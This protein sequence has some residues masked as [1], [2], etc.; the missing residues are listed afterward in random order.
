[1]MQTASGKGKTM[2]YTEFR[3]EYKKAI[4]AYPDIT[5]LYR[6]TEDIKEIYLTCK[7]Y[8]KSG[9]KW[10]QT[11]S[12]PEVIDFLHYINIVDPRTI[13]FFRNLGGYER[14]NKSYTKHGLLPV[15][16]VSINPDR[17]IK[18]V[19]RFSFC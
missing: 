17:T 4:K 16:I 11:A 15:E 8:I 14:V 7:H 19:Y 6:D 10:K 12:K 13:Q 18:S 5:S 3:N 1:M 9:S 2:N